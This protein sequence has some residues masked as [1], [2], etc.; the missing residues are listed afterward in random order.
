MKLKEFKNS[1]ES[2]FIYRNKNNNNINKEDLKKYAI[3]KYETILEGL[4]YLEILEITDDEIESIAL[5]QY[6]EEFVEKYIKEEVSN[7]GN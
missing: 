4:L 1:L 6:G 2:N 7:Y 3:N 5:T